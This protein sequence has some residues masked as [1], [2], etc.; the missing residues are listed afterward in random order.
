MQNPSSASQ[1]AFSHRADEPA[2]ECIS[3]SHLLNSCCVEIVD[4]DKDDI[5]DD[6]G[7]DRLLQDVNVGD[8]RESLSSSQHPAPP[9]SQPADYRRCRPSMTAL[10]PRAG[11]VARSSLVSLLGYYLGFTV[12]LTACV[13]RHVKTQNEIPKAGSLARHK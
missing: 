12:Y 1:L 3:S 10:L 2:I 6:I 4:D 7:M 11:N 8:K 5:G 9:P 13:L